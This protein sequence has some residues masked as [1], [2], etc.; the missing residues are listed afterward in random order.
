MSVADVAGPSVRG[1]TENGSAPVTGLDEAGVVS[2]SVA[3][4]G[5][6]GLFADVS[7]PAFTIFVL[8]GVEACVACILASTA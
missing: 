1:V 8:G 2:F 7:V 5:A 4:A 6:G 3:V